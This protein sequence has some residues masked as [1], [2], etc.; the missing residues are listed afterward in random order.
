MPPPPA[1]LN[2]KNSQ[3]ET[4]AL[5]VEERVG[6]GQAEIAY[7]EDE[8]RRQWH[9]LQAELPTSRVQCVRAQPIAR[10]LHQPVL[11]R[12]AVACKGVQGR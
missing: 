2:S 11:E 12:I 5:E 4:G 9:A 10:Q 7:L 6:G 8:R 1:G 3:R